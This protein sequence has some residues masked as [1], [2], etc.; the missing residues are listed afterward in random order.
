MAPTDPPERQIQT[1]NFDFKVVR[2]YLLTLLL[3]IT[4]GLS[5]W[6]FVSVKNE[7]GNW[8]ESKEF[9]ASLENKI[10]A[11]GN[12]SDA[13]ILLLAREIKAFKA[14][15]LNKM[16]DLKSSFDSKIVKLNLDLLNVQEDMSGVQSDV[17]ELRRSLAKIKDTLDAERSKVWAEFEKIEKEIK[18]LPTAKNGGQREQIYE[19]LCLVICITVF[20]L[21]SMAR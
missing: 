4:L 10:D 6:A 1:R 9:E 17:E 11:F 14:S 5:I 3:I 13:M 15:Y 21:T 8:E 19:T 18:N 7:V 12:K 16:D 2:P 20:V